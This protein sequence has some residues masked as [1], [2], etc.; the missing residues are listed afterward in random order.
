MS[1]REPPA[2]IDSLLSMLNSSS[3]QRTP[4][5][6]QWSGSINQWLPQSRFLQQQ[7]QTSY[8]RVDHHH[9]RP[10][11]VLANTSL[12]RLTN[13]PPINQMNTWATITTPQSTYSH[14]E[15]AFHLMLQQ[16]QRFANSESPIQRDLEQK[17]S[18]REDSGKEDFT[19]TKQ[20]SSKLETP[21]EESCIIRGSDLRDSHQTSS[22][23]RVRTA[24]TS[25]Q[26]L[27][28]E[29]EFANNMYLSRI[30]RIELA[31]KLELTEKQVKIWFQ[32]RR[33]KYKKETGN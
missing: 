33:V 29:R 10:E 24:Y 2:S 31:Q 26:I 28:L 1:S 6:G 11:Q 23:G 8:S 7:Q 3:T 4:N 22:A 30:R 20:V 5:I 9:H 16:Q 14:L 12:Y 19:D 25:M 13:P 27:N 15:A 21:H 17:G 18:S 32:N